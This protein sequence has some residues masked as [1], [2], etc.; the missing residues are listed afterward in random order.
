LTTSVTVTPRASASAL[1]SARILGWK[2]T[3]TTERCGL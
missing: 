3:D 1:M 2:R